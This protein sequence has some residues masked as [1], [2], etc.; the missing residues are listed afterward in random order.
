MI[1]VLKTLPCDRTATQ[2]TDGVGR[3]SE[4]QVS[5]HSTAI[6]PEIPTTAKN[7]KPD[8]GSW[9]KTVMHVQG[10]PVV[11]HERNVTHDSCWKHLGVRSL[12]PDDVSATSEHVK[13]VR[14]HVECFGQPMMS[15]QTCPEAKQTVNCL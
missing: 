11:S 3:G 13:P 10:S 2:Q 8:A 5:L 14:Q 1:N 9:T 12:V 15:D 7:E 6:H 4:T